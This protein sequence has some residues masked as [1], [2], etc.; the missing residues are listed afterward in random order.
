MV[1]A[2]SPSV[3]CAEYYNPLIQLWLLSVDSNASFIRCDWLP[4]PI[5]HWLQTYLIDYLTWSI[6]LFWLIIIRLTEYYN[7][8]KDWMI[9]TLIVCFVIAW[10]MDVLYS[11]LRKI[12]QYIYINASWG[13]NS[14]QWATRFHDT[15]KALKFSIASRFDIPPIIEELFLAFN[16]SQTQ[17]ALSPCDNLKTTSYSWG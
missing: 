6:T 12:H 15:F 13:L 14:T 8:N 1:K 10:T 17:T 11:G 16:S 3:D 5:H 2:R 7:N 9:Q 4:C